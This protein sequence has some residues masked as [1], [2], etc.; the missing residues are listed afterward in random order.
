MTEIINNPET[1][2]LRCGKVLRYDYNGFCMDCADLLGIS[3]LFKNSKN[4]AKNLLIAT[5]ADW[6]CFTAMSERVRVFI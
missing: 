2:C 3:E 1:P 5:K 6:R 4:Y